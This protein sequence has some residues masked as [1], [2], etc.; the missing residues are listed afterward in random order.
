MNQKIKNLIEYLPS[1][2]VNKAI[3][4]YED[5]D[6]EL[7]KEL[8]ENT[9]FDIQSSINIYGKHSKYASID[10]D[11]L[12]ELLKTVEDDYYD[13]LDNLDYL[14]ECEKREFDQSY[15]EYE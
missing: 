4:Y 8:V 15:L 12:E 3:K 9:I 10:L 5:N 11:A 2:E 13:Y 14:K 6:L 1:K 7:L